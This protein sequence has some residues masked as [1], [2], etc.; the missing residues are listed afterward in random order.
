MMHATSLSVESNVRAATTI[1]AA[2][3]LSIA[4]A[5]NP[6]QAQSEVRV[7]VND[8]P[9]TSYDIKTRAQMLRVFSRGAQGEQQAVEQLIDERL[10]LQEA[11]RLKIVVSDAEVDREL[12]DRADREELGP[13]LLVAKIHDMRL[14]LHLLLMERD[15]RLPAEGREG[16]E[17]EHQRHR[18][19]S[20]GHSG[21]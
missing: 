11:K 9:I 6:A 17:I 8:E 12:A 18:R 7:L 19:T 10:M 4:V 16:M 5:I 3:L 2:V 13:G 15:Q 14:E 21:G 20:R 1:L